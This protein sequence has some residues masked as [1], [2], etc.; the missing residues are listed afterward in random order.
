MAKSNLYKK[1]TA[2]KQHAKIGYWVNKPDLMGSC[3]KLMCTYH[4]WYLSHG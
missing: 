2:S 1:N 4:V 3:D